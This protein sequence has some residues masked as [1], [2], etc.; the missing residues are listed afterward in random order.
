MSHVWFNPVLD[1]LCSRRQRVVDSQKKPVDAAPA[2]GGYIL[3]DSHLPASM[4]AT[5]S[6]RQTETLEEV[7]AIDHERHLAAWKSVTFLLKAERWQTISP[8]EINGKMYSRYE[9]HEVFAGLFAYL[10][11]WVVGKDLVA[12]MKTV[13]EELKIR[14]EDTK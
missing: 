7:L 11:K 13:S 4:E 10:V 14:A 8:V 12:A 5:P 3:I 6:T 2:A 1:I 9:T